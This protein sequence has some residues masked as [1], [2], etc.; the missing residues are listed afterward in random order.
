[1][2]NGKGSKQRPLSVDRKTFGARWDATFSRA[3]LTNTETTK[4]RLMFDQAATKTRAT[5]AC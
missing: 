3:P 4:L 2:A 1:M 5:A